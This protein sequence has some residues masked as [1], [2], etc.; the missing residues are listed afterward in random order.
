MGRKV[1]QTHLEEPLWYSW[2]FFIIIPED[3]LCMTTRSCW[4]LRLIE[5][6]SLHL[7]VILTDLK[8]VM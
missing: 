3:D 4:L 8:Y 2:S 6:G 1:F 7:P 5:E